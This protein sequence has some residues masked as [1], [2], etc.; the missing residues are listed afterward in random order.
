MGANFHFDR[1][2]PCPPTEAPEIK[3]PQ[4]QLELFVDNAP[5]QRMDD[6]R[7]ERASGSNAFDTCDGDFSQGFQVIDSTLYFSTVPKLAVLSVAVTPCPE[8]SLG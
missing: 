3:N 1:M 5:S 6:R 2:L 4:R 8:P 7:V